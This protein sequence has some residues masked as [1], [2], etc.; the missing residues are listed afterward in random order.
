MNYWIGTNSHWV[1]LNSCPIR[2]PYHKCVF[3]E[4]RNTVHLEQWHLISNMFRT[5]FVIGSSRLSYRAK[6]PSS[7]YLAYLQSIIAIR[8]T[9]GRRLCMI[10]PAISWPCIL[11][12]KFNNWKSPFFLDLIA[13]LQKQSCILLKLQLQIWYRN[14]AHLNRA[15]KVFGTIWEKL[16]PE[17]L[18]SDW[19]SF[20]FLQSHCASENVFSCI[21]KT[22]T[23]TRTHHFFVWI[24]ILKQQENKYFFLIFLQDIRLLMPMT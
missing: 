18:V 16:G 22:S 23:K 5:K 6:I 10:S 24:N 9:Y 2:P 12:L 3:H 1:L 14:E 4:T 20:H 19:L 7:L 8:I 11:L 21:H 17:K 13:I 15:Q